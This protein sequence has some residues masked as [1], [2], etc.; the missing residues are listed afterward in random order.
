MICYS[1]Q[2]GDCI[3]VKDYGFL[4]FAKNIDKSISINL[5]SNYSQELLDHPKIY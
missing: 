3:F 1:V 2:P 5:N 4:S